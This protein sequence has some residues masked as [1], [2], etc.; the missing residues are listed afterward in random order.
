VLVLPIVGFLDSRRSQELMESMLASVA[1]TQAKSIIIDLT[2]VE[3]VDTGT[4]DHLLKMV[5]AARLLGTQ[6][7]LTGLH[8]AVARTLAELGADLGDVATLRNLKAGLKH[9]LAASLAAPRRD[10]KRS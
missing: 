2:G 5:Q 1:R 3:V 8:P 9:C 10:P 7:L 6:C 4:A